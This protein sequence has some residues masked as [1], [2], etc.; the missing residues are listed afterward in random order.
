MT[1][2]L[3]LTRKSRIQR[4]RSPSRLC[5]MPKGRQMSCVWMTISV[6][7]ASG[8]KRGGVHRVSACARNVPTRALVGRWASCLAACDIVLSKLNPPMMKRS[9]NFAV[10]HAKG[11]IR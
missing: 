6:N 4:A 5:G 3:R 7:G 10:P 11:V 1:R 8:P 2:A 9:R